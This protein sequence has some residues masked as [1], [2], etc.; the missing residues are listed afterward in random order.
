M[1]ETEALSTEEL[2]EYQQVLLQR[3]LLHARDTTSFYKTRLNFDCTSTEAIE[4][5]WN[6]IPVLTRVE[7]SANRD[8]LMS[9]AVP[10]DTGR[11]L[12]EETSGSTG[13]PFEFLKSELTD[14]ATQ[15][16]TERM[17]RWWSMDP[18]KSLA[19]I[20]YDKKKTSPPPEGLTTRYWHSGNPDGRKYSLDAAA[21]TDV[22]L[23]WLR[24]RRPHYLATFSTNL[25]RLALGAVK[26]NLDLRFELVLSFGT[27]VDPDIRT[28]CREAFGAEIADSYGSQE[29]GHVA[30]Q[31]PDCGEYHLAS[32]VGHVEIMRED[33]RAAALG[34]SG[35][36]VVTPFYNYAMPLI[37][38]D[39][40]DFAEAGIANPTCR[41]RLPTLRRILGRARNRFRF[42]D[43]SIIWP[44]LADFRLHELVSY[45]DVQLLQID[46]DHIEIRYV[47]AKAAK[48]VDRTLLEQ[49]IREA[50]GQPVSVSLTAVPNLGRI[51]YGKIEDCVCLLP[52]AQQI[53][54][55]PLNNNVMS[56]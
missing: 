5:K 11:L 25:K 28:A 55:R 56:N 23:D 29:V 37:R 32:E 19:H 33:G 48:P 8:A 4:H 46:L 54:H 15:A 38:Y 51:T 2:I 26:R 44:E 16:L 34:Q 24:D 7:A 35:R 14:V 39:M 17:F 47:P 27:R 30:T 3:L 53:Q 13:I 40:G 10:A 20:H 52:A 41:R 49:R 12:R 36:I 42:R 45:T 6:T 22:Q 9:T 21:S 50:L 43:G 1:A 31:C 18:R